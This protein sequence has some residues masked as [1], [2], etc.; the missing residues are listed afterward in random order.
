MSDELIDRAEKHL[1]AD[2]TMRAALHAA[3]RLAERLSARHEPMA[4]A[5]GAELAEITLPALAAIGD[6][7]S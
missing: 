5:A 1:A 4:K 2:E 3:A 6:A 7:H